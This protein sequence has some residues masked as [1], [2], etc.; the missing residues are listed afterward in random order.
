MI[1]AGDTIDTPVTGERIVFRETSRDTNGEAV[2]IDCFVQPN[3][4]V[5]AAHLHPNQEE[6]FQV[7]SGSVGFRLSK[8]ELVLGQGPRPRGR[9]H[10]AQIL[11]RGQ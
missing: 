3:G 1:R 4:F 8:Q 2:V 5:A 10:T 11:E 6:G 7:L 9:W